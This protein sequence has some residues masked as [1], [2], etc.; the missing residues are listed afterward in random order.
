LAEWTGST[1]T[2]I[3]AATKF[4]RDLLLMAVALVIVAWIM[5]VLFDV[6]Q[7]GPGRAWYVWRYSVS[8]KNVLI[9][10]QPHDCEFMAAPV[11]NKYCHYDKMVN[12]GEDRG[13]RYVIVSWLKQSD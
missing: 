6:L 2:G 5:V 8:P 7:Y 4:V 9:D 13:Q 10:P 1:A 3:I 11:G 12:V